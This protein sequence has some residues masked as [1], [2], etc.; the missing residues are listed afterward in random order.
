MIDKILEL[1]LNNDKDDQHSIHIDVKKPE[2]LNQLDEKLLSKFI[3]PV[4]LDPNQ[5]LQPSS[6]FN[7]GNNNQG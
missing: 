5:D 7:D 3:V 6:S 1:C 4:N 2:K